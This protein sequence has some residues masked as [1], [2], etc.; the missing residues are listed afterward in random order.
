MLSRSL[1]FFAAIALGAASARTQGA[2]SFKLL[3]GD[4]EPPV[5]RL[6][7]RASLALV[8]E[9]ADVDATLLALPEVPNLRVQIYGPSDES[10]SQIVNGRLIESKKVRRW[11][12][13]F[14][15][16]EVGEYAIPALR[17]K[18]WG[19]VYETKALRL[20]CEGAR[21]SSAFL[22]AVVEPATV[23][24]GQEL[25]LRLRLGLEPEQFRRLIS[26]TRIDNAFELRVEFPAWDDFPA[27]GVEDDQ[28]QQVPMNQPL[29]PVNRAYRIAKSGGVVKRGNESFQVFELEKRVRPERVGTFRIDRATLRYA[30]AVRYRRGVFGDVQPSEKSDEF[31][32]SEPLTLE[33]KALPTAGQPK[34]F[35]GAVGD[36]TLSGSLSKNR[37]KVGESFALELQ[38]R[39]SAV[40]DAFEA[41]ELGRLAGFHVFGKKV[42][43]AD[44]SI[45]VRYDL[46]SL[47]PGNREFPIIEIPYFDPDAAEYRFAR[48]GPFKLEATAV[49][50]GKG[51][52]VLPETKKARTPGVDDL[53][54]RMPVTGAAPT[55]FRP[56]ASLAWVALFAPLVLF[57]FGFFAARMRER[58]R[59][60]VAG[61]RRRA[62]Q[63]QF[64][65]RLEADGPLVALSHFVA[66]R[67]GWEPGAVLG[68]DLESRLEQRGLTAERAGETAAL[69]ARLEAGRYAGGREAELA[70]DARELVKTLD[71]ELD[72]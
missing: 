64:N 24:L 52:E 67:L 40:S 56:S 30:W 61:R 28:L 4:L 58:R 50:G 46:S 32:R 31:A 10:S 59:A 36:L 66:D 7:G 6:G 34:G 43:R 16:L 5:V 3:V 35:G 60:D 2:A 37:V 19:K 14:E 42:D 33:V 51:L 47:V 70:R 48:A 8:A 26:N 9:N 20:T 11:R 45:V 62:A 72:R 65:V 22:E 57:G 54:D 18:A 68:P 25:K 38:A 53:W 71:K 41:P 21:E 49:A 23:W 44:D 1:C 15:P 27:G 13:E 63:Q 69:F 39:G 17:V 12:V 55:R 29:V